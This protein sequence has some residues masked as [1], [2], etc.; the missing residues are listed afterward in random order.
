MVC[1]RTL[2]D[3][4]RWS[5]PWTG[6][7]WSWR[8]CWRDSAARRTSNTFEAMCDAG[9]FLALV[10]TATSSGGCATPPS[11]TGCRGVDPPVPVSGR[12]ADLCFVTARDL[13]VPWQAAPVEVFYNCMS[14]L[15]PVCSCRNVC[16]CRTGS[17]KNARKSS[18]SAASA[19]AFDAT[20]GRTFNNQRVV[21]RTSK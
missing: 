15:I 4:P 19:G 3:T 13:G 2:N 11:R 21:V 17:I 9:V 16:A 10:T 8:A 18:R 20:E 1:E 5:T 12:T 14:T 7:G 6:G